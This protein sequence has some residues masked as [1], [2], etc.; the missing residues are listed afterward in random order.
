MPDHVHGLMCFPP[1]VGM[2]KTLSD[3]KHF[4]ARQ[5]GIVWQRGFFDHRL[6]SDEA[7]VEK[8]HYIRMNP[9]RAGLVT[10]P[11][12]WP[13]VWSWQANEQNTQAE[14]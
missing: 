4:T 11:E 7:Y 14:K 6:R 8:A 9:V 12:E 2:L 1:Q 5:F 3:W 10:K 13:H